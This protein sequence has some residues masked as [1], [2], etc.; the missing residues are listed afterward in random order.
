MSNQEGSGVGSGQGG[1]SE[2]PLA[3][4]PSPDATM[5]TKAAEIDD[6]IL[7]DEGAPQQLPPVTPSQPPLDAGSKGPK[8]RKS[9]SKML[10]RIPDDQIVRPSSDKMPVAEPPTPILTIEPPSPDPPSARE[11]LVPGALPPLPP[12]QKTM[13]DEDSWTPFQPTAADK[14]DAP[15]SARNGPASEEIL[16]ETEEPISDGSVLAAGD[17]N[18]EAPPTVP[19]FAPDFGSEGDVTEAAKARPTA[20]EPTEIRAEDLVAV[21][22]QPGRLPSAPPMRP[23]LGSVPPVPPPRAKAP[24][25]PLALGSSPTPSRPA[26]SPSVP[27]VT[28]AVPN[29]G[30]PKPPPPAASQPALSS[31]T[32][33]V[34]VP[35]VVP[36]AAR[37]AP[38]DSG[39][40]PQ[41]G[42]VLAPPSMTDAAGRKRT[43]PWWEELFN[44]DFLRATPRMTDQQIGKECD[45]IEESLGVARG[46]MVLDLACGTGRHAI[47]LVRRGYQVAG[48]DLSLPMLARAA[49]EAEERGQTLNFVQGDMRDMVYEEMF[50]GI[51]SWNT[52]FGFFEEEKNAQVIARVHRALKK[53]GQFLL[54]VVNRDFIGRQAPSLVWFEGDGC[55]CMDEMS[56]DWITSRMR[57]KRTMML[58]DGRTREIEYSLRLYALHELGRLLH[59]HG[60]RVA[61]VS[62]STA[63]PG[64]F[65]G[66]DSPRTMILA[67]K[68]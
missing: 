20:P 48:Y 49:E 56:I 33:A 9:R 7:E 6:I 64:V 4:R 36:P 10:L 28:P 44:D 12:P 62:G 40:T 1:K 46:A 61:E 60:F 31:K 59:E 58:D 22:S 25:V 2:I 26:P 14:R 21:E 29:H 15:A 39:K 24:S 55:I 17:V 57:V 54:D 8:E 18:A 66:G 42:N 34:A 51:Y 65:F 30:A 13:L 11:D 38:G 16:V 32:P 43:R 5:R 53:G 37:S 45:F 3:E 23:R 41:P 19:H 35:A 50:D 68:R 52:S 27:P 67:E 47:E 63:T